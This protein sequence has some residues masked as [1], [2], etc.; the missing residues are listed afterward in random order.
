MGVLMTEAKTCRNCGAKFNGHPL[1]IYCS[2]ICRKEQ[3]NK[4]Y[5]EKWASREPK[6]KKRQDLKKVMYSDF[7]EK[8]SSKFLKKFQACRG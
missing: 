3:K 4:K 1:A 7:K 6:E 5:I 8:P 2:D